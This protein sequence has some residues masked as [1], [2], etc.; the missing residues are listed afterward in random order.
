MKVV[1]GKLSL[2]FVLK[3]GAEVF[4]TGTGASI[5]PV[6]SITRGVTVTEFSKGEVGPITGKLFKMISDIQME[7]TA[8]TNKWL[9]DPWQ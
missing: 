8:D 4:C 9:F 6:G 3:E 2:E 5:T 7:R 1:E